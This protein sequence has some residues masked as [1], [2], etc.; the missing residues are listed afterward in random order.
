METELALAKKSAYAVGIGVKQRRDALEIAYVPILPVCSIRISLRYSFREQVVRTERL[1]DETVKKIVK[2]T[3]DIALWK[4]EVSN[5]LNR[6]RQYA[7]A[8]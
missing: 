2:S 7:E 8:N 4:T 3:S 5:Q 6:L 1:K